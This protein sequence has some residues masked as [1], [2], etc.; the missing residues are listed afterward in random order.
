MSFRIAMINQNVLYFA[1]V[2]TLKVLQ[3]QPIVKF[4]VSCK[5]SNWINNINKKYKNFS[6]LFNVSRIDE[7]NK[8]VTLTPNK[9]ELIFEYSSFIKFVLLWAMSKWCDASVH[10][11]S[12]DFALNMLVVIK[13]LIS[14]FFVNVKLNRLIHCL[15]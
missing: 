13:K 15:L 7:R 8:L 14:L 10:S 9:I 12:F 2:K 3:K 6:S 11:R 4:N 1:L 5:R